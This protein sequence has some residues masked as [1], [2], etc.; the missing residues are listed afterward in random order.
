MKAVVLCAGMGTRLGELTKETPKPLLP[1]AG[2]P[3]LVHT[4]EYLKQYGFEDVGINLHFHPDKIKSALSKF[5]HLGVRIHYSFEPELLGTA[6]ALPAFRQWIGNESVLVMYGD[7]LTSQNLERFWA[8]HVSAN[9]FATLLLHRRKNSNSFVVM[10][11]GNRI[12][13]FQERPGVKSM[14]ALQQTASESWVN[15]GVQILSPACLDF[16]RETGAF[17]LP[18]DVYMK[19]IAKEK[20]MGQGLDAFRIA[21]DS[22]ERFQNAVRA[23]ESGEYSI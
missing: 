22:P 9:A 3:L 14:N 16:I 15:S 10:D 13:A 19:T 7:I 21:I 17:D 11:E 18:K 20:I 4:L 6:G 1:L 23:V 5:E 12:T 2:K 8:R